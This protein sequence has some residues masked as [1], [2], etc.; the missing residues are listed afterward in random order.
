MSDGTKLTG[1]YGTWQG[2][3]WELD[4]SAPYNGKLTL[5]RD[6]GEQPEPDWKQMVYPNRFAR[7]PLHFRKDVDAGEVSDVHSIKATAM[8][9]QHQVLV[10][11]EDDG[12]RLAVQ[13]AEQMASETIRRFIDQFGF[14][15]YENAFVFGWVEPH[16]LRD[17][18]I[19][20]TERVHTAS[21][22]S[23]QAA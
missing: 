21:S 8:L 12:E 16:A 18:N 11:A 3:E 17:L 7:T 4:G 10:I 22:R 9:D 5:I 15:P 14:E 2:R 23:E 13:T 6:G 19:E 20:R 1:T